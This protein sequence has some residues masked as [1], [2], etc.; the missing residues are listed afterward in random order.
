MFIA[1]LFT[2]AKVLKQ[3]TCS[4]LGELN[5]ENVVDVYNQYYSAMR[6]K[7]TAICDNM[8]EL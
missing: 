3:P 4:S 1:T 2:V 8:H 6:K 7:K 5:K